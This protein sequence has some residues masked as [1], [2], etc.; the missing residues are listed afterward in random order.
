MT[1]KFLT[2]IVVTAALFLV[3]GTAIA[4]TI[5]PTARTVTTAKLFADWSQT[6]PEEIV[7]L[8]WAG[9]PNLT[10]TAA[11]PA[12]S[13]DLEYFGDS[14]VTQDEGTPDFVFKSLVGWGTTGTWSAGPHNSVQIDSISSGCLGS[15]NIPVETNY[16][17]YDSGPVANRIWMQRRF[18]FG[19][20]PFAYDLRPY[21]PR[22]YTRS[23]Y[24]QVLH[25]DAGGTSLLTEDSTPPNCDFGCRVNDWNGTWFA[26]H[27]P[28]TGKGL[29]VKHAPSSYGVALWVDQDSA[30]D[31]TSSGVML[32]QPGGGF[33]GTV[34][35]VESMCFYDSSI[36]SPSLSLPPGC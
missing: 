36:W 28:T 4:A 16:R 21:I 24:N 17:F 23:D 29:I 18:H 9:S 35:E 22:L 15:A 31:T 6:N 12:C 1:K 25:P 7:D 26:V 13:S 30:S 10:N 11:K 33:T 32:L 19:S 34:V 3:A 2:G 14:W 5:D 20:T 8:Q 27:N